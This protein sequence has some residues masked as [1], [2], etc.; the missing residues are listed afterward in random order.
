MRFFTVLLLTVTTWFHLNGQ[1]GL[2]G[3]VT[4]P[5]GNPL[6][7]VTV[8][9]N[10]EPGKGVLTDIEG[11]FS[12]D[13]GI[14]FQALGFRY[15]GYEPLVLSADFWK[16]TPGQP[17]HVVLQPADYA[18]PEATVRAGENPADIL[19]R[20]AIANRKRNNPELR[21]AYR[22]KTY[23]KILFDAV[24]RRAVFEERYAGRDTSNTT[25]REAREKFDRLEQSMEH[26][27]GFL[28]ESVTE[29]AF[30]FPNQVQET[31]LLN[32]VSG[33]TNAGLV[34]LANMVQP[35]SFY[36]D[37]LT[38]IDKNFVNPVSPGSPDLYFFHIED[39]LY[40]GA[41]TV[42]VISFHPR[43]GKVF[44]GLE[45]VLHLHSRHWAIQNVRAQPAQPGN[46]EL[47]IEQAYQLVP[48]HDGQNN[49]PDSVA[50]FPAQLNFE[51]EFKKYPAPFVGLRSAGR[52]YIADVQLDTMPRLRDFNL[53]TPILM[54]P[55]ADD[56]TDSSWARWRT[57]APLSAKEQRTYQWLDSLGAAKNFDRL[58]SIMDLLTTGRAPIGGSILSFDF[59]HLLKFNDYEGTRLGIGLTTGQAKPLRPQRRLELGA[60]LGYGFRDKGW[61][62]G[63]YALWR[64]SP[65]GQ[66]QL[67]LSWRRDLLEPGTSYELPPPALVNRGL[68][69][70]RMDRVDEFAAAM[71]SR[72]GRFFSFAGTFRHQ[73]LEP[74]YA[75][76]F[77][78]PDA[79][80]TNQFRFIEG[81]L[82]LRYANG[83]RGGTF[84]GSDVGTTQR[85]PVF[86]LA[87]TRGEWADNNP[88]N[89]GRGG[90]YERWTAAVY[91]SFFLGRLGRSRWR[92]EAG[93]AS[94]DAPLAKLFTLNQ[95]GGGLSLFVIPNT[96]QALPDTLFL[97]NRFANFYFAQEI[98]PVL[99]QHKRS[100]PFLTLLQHAAWGDLARS[101]L[102]HDV[103]FRAAT[104]ALLE[105]GIQLDNLLRLNYVNL[106]HIG[107]GG[108]VFYRWGGLGSEKWQDNFSFR[109]SLRF[110]L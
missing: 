7:F 63:G 106:A 76:R 51:M 10:N 18:L 17:L 58:S 73:Q 1:S 83:E 100:S 64:I 69:A 101:D 53:E 44:D 13:G 90:H 86:E 5:Q 75:Y 78:D 40:T 105:S 94:K 88:A 109:M 62:Y 35:F 9:L 108:A 95:S 85:L 103:G 49:I 41:D 80:L 25:V 28:M 24:P 12:I 89:A 81:S 82:F 71:S 48:V 36:G 79:V 2:S 46:L 92:L 3:S 27:H 22:C 68:Y 67:R 34:A 47:T 91:H 20:K 21:S 14:G 42:W 107:L 98:G 32:R 104:P 23:N 15:V 84:L 33:F 74:G 52:S 93:I 61:K 19:I 50:W 77:G 55:D 65:A 102:H 4:D 96:F 37:Y 6:A 31:V 59:R 110:V 57:L 45:G 8:L 56:R 39:S 97:A 30:R 16:K 26:N 54:N 60:N 70:S 38:I 11:R 72:L 43:R 99:Y 66:P 87:Y 29:R